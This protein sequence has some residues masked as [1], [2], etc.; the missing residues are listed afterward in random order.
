MKDLTVLLQKGGPVEGLDN[1]YWSIF[2]IT[3]SDWKMIGVGAI[4]V[5][6]GIILTLWGVP[7]ADWREALVKGT[8]SRILTNNI[9]KAVR[10]VS[11]LIGAIMMYPFFQALFTNVLVLGIIG[12][13]GYSLFKTFLSKPNDEES[14]N[15]EE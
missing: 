13:V 11:V 10:V 15:M 12:V 2:E 3:S 8:K 6:I 1:G 14:D 4:L 7:Q 9:G 5:A